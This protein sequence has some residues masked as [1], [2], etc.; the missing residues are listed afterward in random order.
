AII[1]GWTGTEQPTLVRNNV[2]VISVDVPNQNFGLVNGFTLTGRTFN[3][4]G[5]GGGIANDGLIN[6][7]EAGLAGHQIR[8]TDASGSVTF[9]TAISAA[10]G[11]F[12]LF[13]PGAVNP[14]TQLK[15]VETNPSGLLSTGGNAGSSGGTYD[16]AADT[17]TFIYGS[18]NVQGLQFGN[19]AQN[20]FLNDSQ[21][22]GLPG[23]FVLHPHTFIANSAGQLTFSLSSVASPN[24]S[25]WTPIIYL[26]ANCNGQLDS[27]EAPITGAL[28]ASFGQQICI[29]IKDTIP[30]LAPFNAQHQITITASFNYSSANPVLVQASARTALTI[31][32]N[33]TTAGLTLTKAVDKNAA[34]PGEIITYTL[35]YANQSSQALNNIVVF[36]STPA[37]TTFLSASAGPLPSNLSSVTITNP[38]VGG[39]GPIHWTFSGALAPGQT[40]TVIFSVMVA[41]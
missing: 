26:D 30:L 17:V 8:L 13:I 15:V 19:V 32:G 1:S 29:L 7:S 12:S 33:P 18:T 5:I 36:D 21:Q 31:V 10:S 11:Q 28:A 40:G 27:G 24:I 14:G 39:S 34:L 4:N 37:F 3:D 38:I 25:G 22:T 23:S 9:S 41:Q 35:T 16:R 2:L 6:G 20:T